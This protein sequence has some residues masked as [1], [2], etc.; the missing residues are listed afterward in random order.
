MAEIRQITNKSKDKPHQQ[1]QRV[2]TGQIDVEA[3]TVEDSQEPLL[4]LDP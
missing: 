3:D 2:E 1:E 4:E